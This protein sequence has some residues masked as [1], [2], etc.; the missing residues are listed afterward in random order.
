MYRALSRLQDGS[1]NWLKG[2]MLILTYLFVAAGFWVGGSAASCTSVSG[3]YCMSMPDVTA[4]A[5]IL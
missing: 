3:Q 1:S 5:Q 4:A 2:S